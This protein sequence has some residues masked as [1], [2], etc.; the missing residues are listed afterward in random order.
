[1]AEPPPAR[2]PGSRWVPGY[3]SFVGNDWVWVKGHWM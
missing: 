3:W 2:D 1:M